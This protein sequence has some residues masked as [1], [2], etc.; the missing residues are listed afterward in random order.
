[1][2][3]G[4]CSLVS[5]QKQ[6]VYEDDKVFVFIPA[7]IA[8]PG[9]LIV[10]PKEH[11]PILEQIPDT[12]VAHLFTIAAKFSS[13]IYGLFQAEGVNLFVQNGTSAGQAVAH[14]VVHIIPR[15]QNDKLSFDWTPK[16]IS[17]DE[18]STLEIQIKEKAERIMLD[19]EKPEPV[20]M[21]KPM[22]FKEEEGEINYL[23]KQLERMP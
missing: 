1:M 17:E 3:C 19:K 11:F 10:A 4:V 8:V 14:T 20:E 7:K 22:A 2:T 9:H 12:V 6:I 21:P 23:I 18:M 15:K 16:E 5:E 13:L